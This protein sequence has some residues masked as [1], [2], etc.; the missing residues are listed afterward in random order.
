MI[1]GVHVLTVIDRLFFNRKPERRL[2]IA[3]NYMLN[4][5]IKSL[6]K[7]INSHL[8]TFGLC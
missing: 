3:M 5:I 2:Y 8:Q 1:N 4:G 7:K 6:E